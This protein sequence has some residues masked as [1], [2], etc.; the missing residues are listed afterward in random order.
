MSD[1]KIDEGLRS[2]IEDAVARA[3]EAGWTPNEVREEVDYAIEAFED[4]A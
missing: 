1:S 4:A 2:T 3:L